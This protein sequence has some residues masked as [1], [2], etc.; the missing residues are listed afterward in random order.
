MADVWLTFGISAGT[1]SIPN[2][3]TPV[4]VTVYANWRYGYYNKNNKS[5]TLTIDGTSYSFT[6]PFNT[7]VASSGSS[8]LTSRTVN[9]KHNDNGTKT[10]SVSASYATGVVGTVSASTSKKLTDI[11]RVSDLVVNI[12]TVPADGTS[13]VIAT[14]TKKATSFTDILTVTLG[15]YS[16]E[17]ESG[18]AF[19]IPK[20]W[21]NAISGTS[22]TATVKVETFSGTTSIGSKTAN[23]TITV[24]ESVV[25]VIND[26]NISEAV[27]SVTSAFGNLFVQNLS[28]LNVSID[29]SGAYGSTIRSYSATLDGVNYIQQAFT[30]NVIKTAGTLEI[31]VKVTDSRGRIAEES[32]SVN[33]VEY[34]M[35][36]ITSMVYVHCDSDGTQNSSGNCT[37]LTIAGRVYPVEGQNTKAL[38]LKYKTTA[39][40]TY[41]ERVVTLSDWTFNI[42]VIINNTDPTVTY[43]YIAELTDKINADSPESSRVI[44]GV[45]VISRLAGG[46]GVTL[47]GEAKDEGFVVEG[48]KP[49][50]FTGNMFFKN[51]GNY[52][53]GITKD[54]KILG[55]FTPVTDN[56]MCL[57]GYGGYA[58]SIGGTGIYGN[59]INFFTK[60]K[61]IVPHS[62]PFGIHALTVGCSEQ[63]TLSTSYKK[64]TLGNVYGNDNQVTTGVLEAYNGGIRVLRK[65]RYLVSAILYAESMTAG[66]ILCGNIYL[67]DVDTWTVY[68]NTGDRTYTSLAIPPK[69]M[70]ADANSIFCLHAKNYHSA[71]GKVLA[72]HATSLTVVAI[73]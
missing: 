14:A 70:S 65:G 55:M 72:T 29:A 4:T 28:Q 25:P 50:K 58:E 38:K 41:T 46:K 17:V 35:P 57:L 47:F 62:V 43:E 67:N 32:I 13:K 44:T 45:P 64:A 20:E 11:P 19:S 39:D 73:D 21:N 33:I 68:I 59:E 56:N 71:T 31:A 3:T 6:S 16:Q 10:V 52:I 49:A 61:T 7:G 51:N 26:I 8:T 15:D 37:K 69:V 60:G 2:N 9:V 66:N 34:A 12:E 40:E 27:A 22:A 63:L 53:A 48:S 24:P 42:D 18:V 1:P 5:G 30:S 23:L 54:G 36:T